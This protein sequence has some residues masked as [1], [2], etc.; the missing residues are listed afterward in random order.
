M[1][2]T[3]HAYG[4]H[5]DQFAELTLPDAD[6]PADGFPVAAVVHG[7]FWLA[8]NT[9]DRM[10]ALCA[11][12]AARGWAAWNV[13]YRRLG[14]GSD[15]GYP[16]TP[17]DVSAAID[18]LGTLTDEPLDL[19]RVVSIGHSAG[20]HLVLLDAARAGAT[21][22][23]AGLVAPAPLTDVGLAHD[24]R[25]GIDILEAFMGGGPAQLPDVYAE[26]SPVTR[27]PLGVPQLVV[28]GGRDEMVP[29]Q[30]VVDYVE[31]A[32]MAGDDVTVE[33]RADDGHF[34]HLDPATEAWAAVPA[35]L[36][37]FTG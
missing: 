19:T 3:R 7:G 28:Q 12:L 21:V 37:R 15:G 36:E 9:M 26:A 25:R 35:W 13:E 17:Q 4:D 5:P 32:Q 10:E 27:V 33:L 29:P 22:R 30:M 2:G 11:D 18:H 20:A 14:D 8:E 1:P 31:A 24:M 23:V 34:E 6:P 16:Q